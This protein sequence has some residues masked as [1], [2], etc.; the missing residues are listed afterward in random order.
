MIDDLDIAKMGLRDLRSRLTI[1][2]QVYFKMFSNTLVSHHQDPVIFSGTI[3]DNLDPF[4]RHDSSELWSALQLTHLDDFVK[5]LPDKLEHVI[6]EG[7]GNLRFFL[8][9]F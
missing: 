4:S 8:S 6:S 1:V 2:P 7:G 9:F 5:S 3:R